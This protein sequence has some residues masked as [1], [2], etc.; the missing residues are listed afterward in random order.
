MKKGNKTN[1]IRYLEKRNIPHDVVEYDME[2]EGDLSA[3]HVSEV[4]GIPVSMLYK[5]IVCRGD[6]TGVILACVP[7]D[8]EVDMKKL[9]KASGNKKVESVPVKEILPL[10]G[11][12]RGGVSPIGCKKDY[13]LYVS[14]TI[15]S[16]DRIY[17]SAGR[18][19][20]QIAIAPDDLV[21]VREAKV[22]PITKEAR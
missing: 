4:S 13:P 19:G 1:A 20:C 18:K 17:I 8:S 22:C 14:D 5:T 3:S 16:K 12:I 11:Y 6:K 10:T 7:G 9:A 21:A 15:R 2:D